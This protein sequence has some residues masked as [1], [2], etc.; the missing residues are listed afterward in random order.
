MWP[1]CHTVLHMYCTA[2]VAAAGEATQINLDPADT[3]DKENQ[4][5][6]VL[7]TM[8]KRMRLPHYGKVTRSNPIGHSHLPARG[9]SR[10]AHL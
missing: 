7:T 1:D 10:P 2:V 8:R 5:K 3:L 9:P 4:L 6:S